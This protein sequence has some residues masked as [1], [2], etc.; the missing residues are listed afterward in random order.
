MRAEDASMDHTTSAAQYSAITPG[1][2]A[3]LLNE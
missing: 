3:D 2:W 1:A